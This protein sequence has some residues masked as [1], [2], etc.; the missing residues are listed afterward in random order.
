MSVLALT[1]LVSGNFA[2]KMDRDKI[3]KIVT[4]D[5]PRI[6]KNLQIRNGLSIQKLKIDQL[7]IG[8]KF[9]NSPVDS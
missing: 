4:I 7:E 8:S 1:S 6:P 3:P 2:P 9:K 5:F